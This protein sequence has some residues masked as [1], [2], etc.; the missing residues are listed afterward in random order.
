M[1]T[2]NSIPMASIGEPRV[3]AVELRWGATMP[4]R[5]VAELLD[6]G[7]MS[8]ATTNGH[9]NG[10]PSSG[11]S[12]RR[13]YFVLTI[14]VVD[15]RGAVVEA[16]VESEGGQRT[17]VDRRRIDCDIIVDGDLLHVDARR[18]SG[19]DGKFVSLSMRM[20]GSNDED[21]RPGLLYA[22]TTLLAAAGL[23]SGGYDAPTA[24]TVF[25]DRPAALTGA[26]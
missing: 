26:C 11:A 25:G 23:E 14:E 1:T 18:G 15:A 17:I 10:S 13:V 16:R 12:L 6:Q 8:S 9:G 21:E 2:A 20:G 7:T 24:R 4:A 19:G 3:R 5:K 22:Q